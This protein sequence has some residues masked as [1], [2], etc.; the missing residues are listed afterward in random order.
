MPLAVVTGASRGLGAA[1]ARELGARGWDLLLVA[2]DQPRLER[3]AAEIARQHGVAV[4]YAVQDLGAPDAAQ[5]LYISARER[6]QDVGLLINNAGFGLY[7]EF[8]E[9]PMPHLQAMLR[10]HVNTVVESMRL[11]LPA[12]V[13]R[14]AGAIINVASLAG[15]FAIPYFAE[16]GATKSFLITFSEAIAEEVRPFGVRIQAC[17]PGKTRTDFHAT[18]GHETRNVLG[19]RT[20]DEVVR[21]SLSQLDGG[22]VVLTIGWRE[23]AVARLVRFLP[24]G[25]LARAA[26]RWMKVARKVGNSDQPRQHPHG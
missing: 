14:R 6:G 13:E 4:T 24:R 18:A 7:G 1:Y 10:V 26:A 22:P 17:C 3:L 20:A 19:I 8:V 16:Y 9:T 5:R 2:R 21:S 23:G 15:F 12:M 11:F 25:L